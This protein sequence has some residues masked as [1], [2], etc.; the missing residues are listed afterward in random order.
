MN[1]D[2]LDLRSP[3][4]WDVDEG[5][6]ANYLSRGRGVRKQVEGIWCRPAH[7]L[8]GHPTVAFLRTKSNVKNTQIVTST[9]VRMQLV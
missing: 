5:G 4:S 9:S 6:G 2:K 8:E 1:F 7:L 3:Q